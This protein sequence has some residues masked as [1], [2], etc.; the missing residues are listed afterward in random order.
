[1]QTRTLPRTDLTVSRACFGAMTFGGQTD[2]P[3]AARMIDLCIDR[4]INFFD[5]ANAYNKGQS[6][7]ILGNILKGR[8][9]GLILASKVGTKTGEPP[10]ASP[11]SRKSILANIDATLR[12]LQTDYLDIYYFHMPDYEAALDESLEALHQVVKAGKVRYPGTSNFAA[13]QV[14]QALWIS[15]KKGYAPPCISQPMYNLLARGI[16]QEYIPFCKQFGVS[17][18]VYNPLAGGLLT[19]KQNRER[20]LS[21]TR[22]DANQMYL[23]RYW[24]PAYFDAVDKLQEIAQKAGRSII[25]VAL[26]WLLFHTAADCVILGASKIAQ[27]EQNLDVFGRAPLDAATVGAC[28]QVWQNLRGVT[29]KYNR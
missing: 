2:E 27:L 22:F 11:L 12:R 18:V 15:E 23:D 17:M 1:M 25:D 21:G 3:A 16:E 26:N 10:D 14:E 20:P 7:V 4:G 28:D 8:R 9:S 6:E 19:G 24:H 29:P 13:W 5:T